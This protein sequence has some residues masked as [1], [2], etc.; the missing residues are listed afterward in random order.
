[1]RKLIQYIAYAGNVVAKIAD[2]R[3][4]FAFVAVI[5]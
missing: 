1:L 3:T 2:L 4:P 5:F